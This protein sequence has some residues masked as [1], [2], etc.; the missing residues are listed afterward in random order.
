MVLLRG[1]MRSESIAG[2]VHRLAGI[3]AAMGS[4]ARLRIMQLLLGAHPHGMVVN[5]DLVQILTESGTP[6]TGPTPLRFR[7]QN[8]LPCGAAVIYHLC[9]EV[10]K[11]LQMLTVSL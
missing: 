9:P 5:G 10:L 6:L 11:H 2:N 4:E 3:L 1:N 8:S 7:H